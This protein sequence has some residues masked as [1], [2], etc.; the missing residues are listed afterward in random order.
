VGSGG[1]VPAGVRASQAG[2]D[3]PPAGAGGG[4]TTHRSHTRAGA[5]DGGS[6]GGGG[7]DGDGG[8][9]AAAAAAALDDMLATAG[10]DVADPFAAGVLAAGHEGGAVLAAAVSAGGARGDVL[11]LAAR[12]AESV[13]CQRAARRRRWQF[14]RGGGR[15]ARAAV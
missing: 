7:D 13:S 9:D 2:M 11:G 10:V 6:G 15:H 4:G 3:W 1:A 5:V 14:Q 12:I 8:E